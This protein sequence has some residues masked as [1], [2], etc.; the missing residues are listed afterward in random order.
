MYVCIH[1]VIDERFSFKNLAREQYYMGTGR[2]KS[3]P[4][5]LMQQKMSEN[6]P[7]DG[8][9]MY[10]RCT[11]G[12]LSCAAFNSWMAHGH[13]QSADV[14]RSPNR[15]LYFRIFPEDRVSKDKKEAA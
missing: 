9:G 1:V 14:S 10:S 8:C 15:E 5:A 11:S 2:I 3:G 13:V 7:C 6:R 4:A 12:R